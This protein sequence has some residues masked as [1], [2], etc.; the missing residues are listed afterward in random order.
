[1]LY[2]VYGEKDEIIKEIETQVA[3]LKVKLISKSSILNHPSTT[4]NLETDVTTWHRSA[5][6]E[7]YY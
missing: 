6:I 5:G 7:T 4:K 1:M 3:A 2:E